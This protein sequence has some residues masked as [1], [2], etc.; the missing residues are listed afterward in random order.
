MADLHGLVDVALLPIW[1]WGHGL[2]PA[3][4]IQNAAHEPL[5]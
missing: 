2:A 5:G 1:G 4:W 3:T